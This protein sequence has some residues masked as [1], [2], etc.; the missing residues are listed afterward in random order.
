VLF[1]FLSFNA[2]AF[3]ISDGGSGMKLSGNVG[4]GAYSTYYPNTLDNASYSSC[5]IPYSSQFESLIFDVNGDFISDVV[6]SSSSAIYVYDFN[7]GLIALINMAPSLMPE[8]TNLDGDSDLEISFVSGNIIYSYEY[9]DGGFVALG[10]NSVP[11]TPDMFTC[12]NSYCYV[13]DTY[14]AGTPL[15]VRFYTYDFSSPE[16]PILYHNYTASHGV[17]AAT[18]LTDM[19]GTGSMRDTAAYTIDGSNAYIPFISRWMDSNGKMPV[20]IFNDDGTKYNNFTTFSSTAGAGAP[21]TKIKYQQADIVNIGGS[22]YILVT[23]GGMDNSPYAW[24][25]QAIYSLDGTLMQKL[26]EARG[27]NFKPRYSNFITGLYDQTAYNRICLL[28]ATATSHYY[29]DCWDASINRIYHTNFSQSFTAINTSG[30]P[31]GVVMADFYSDSDRL[32]FADYRGIYC[33]DGI[34]IDFNSTALGVGAYNTKD[35]SLFNSVSIGTSYSTIPMFVINNPTGITQVYRNTQISTTCGDTVCDAWENWFTC[36]VDCGNLTV[37]GL[38]STGTFCNAGVEC[39]TGLCEYNKCTLLGDNKECLYSDQCLSGSC[40]NGHCTKPSLWD[41][42]D[43]SKEQQFGTGTNTNNFIA[44]FIMIGIAIMIILAGK[45]TLAIIAGV[46]FFY[47]MGFFFAMVGWLSPF[48][49]LGLV[50]VALIGFV[51]LF[52]TGGSSD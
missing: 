46:A 15:N 27:S 20:I 36:S 45:S 10:S 16:A 39:Y 29:V 32:C 1:L 11:F 31:Y 9:V 3:F 44:L 35:R 17:A 40:V 52:M 21:N 49:L 28:N 8:R 14:D 48:I 12:W 34:Y 4:Q 19:D 7:C 6:V 30:T 22:N 37:G 13:G 43:Y 41:S 25:Y 51:L 18:W 24:H 47:V 23:V 42:L 5:T 50:F 38:N 2:Q 33:D 26:Q